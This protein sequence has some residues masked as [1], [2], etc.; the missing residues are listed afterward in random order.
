MTETV[1]IA[2]LTLGAIARLTRLVVEDTITAP[3]RAVVELRGVKSSG[4]RWVSELIRCQW[5]ASIWIAAGAAAA[6]YWWHDA[7]L[8][9]YAAGALTASHLVALGASWLDAPPPVKQHEIAPVQLV[10]TLRDQRRR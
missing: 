5:C 3:L 9:V 2:L 4:W 7:A 6:H 10:L 1:L 8:F